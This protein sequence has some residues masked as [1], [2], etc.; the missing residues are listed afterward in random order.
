M[1]PT[2]Y[3][4]GKT[5]RAPETRRDLAALLGGTQFSAGR[6]ALQSGLE[7]RVECTLEPLQPLE[8]FRGYVDGSA[9]GRRL[10]QGFRVAHGNLG[11]ISG[12][13]W[14]CFSMQLSEQ[15][16]MGSSSGT[17]PRGPRTPWVADRTSSPRSM[18]LR[19]Y[20]HLRVMPGAHRPS[21]KNLE[22][23]S[24]PDV[25]STAVDLT[26]GLFFKHRR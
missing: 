4:Q 12:A 13:S 2:N 21:L 26:Q 16:N 24:R 5:T 10:V 8:D 9:L 18:A 7:A 3:H 15:N 20:V 17:N 23:T 1:T 22:L 6:S 11:G 25:L 19:Q 14:K